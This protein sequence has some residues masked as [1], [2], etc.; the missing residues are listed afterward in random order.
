MVDLPVHERAS[1]WVS[2]EPLFALQE[3]FFSRPLS[4]S[5]GFAASFKQ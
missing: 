3:A 2:R 1:R 5:H 4:P